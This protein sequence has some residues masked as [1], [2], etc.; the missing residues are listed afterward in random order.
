[1]SEPVVHLA[2]EFLRKRAETVDDWEGVCGELANEVITEKDSIIHVDGCVRWRYHMV[3]YIDGL[4]HD[5]WCPGPPLPVKE[6]LRAM[7]PG[8]CVEVLLNGDVVYYG[9]VE[10]FEEMELS[11]KPA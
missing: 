7:F 8:E 9:M 2:R 6:W 11:T 5:A 1:M 10:D 4:V 3:P